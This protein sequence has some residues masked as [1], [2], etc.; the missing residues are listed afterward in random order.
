MPY[1]P[2]SYWESLHRRGDL[3]AVG[4]SGLPATLN[5]WLYRIHQRNL[6]ALIDA[7][8]VRPRTVFEIGAGTGVFVQ[9]WR[10]RGA[11]R[12]DGC[13]L[14]P[15]V[16][17]RLNVDHGDTGRFIQADVAEPIPAPLSDGYDVVSCMNVL[18]HI[19]DDALFERA[20]ANISRLVASGGWL[21]LTEPVLYN[22]EFEVPP[23]PDLSSRARPLALYR[24]PAEASGLQLVEVRASTALGN[25]PI[26]ARNRLRYWG[27]RALWAAVGAPCR[28]VPAAARL[29]GPLLWM[30]DPWALRLGAAPSG[31]LVLFR[32]PSS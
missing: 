2:T 10:G 11:E 15:S 3:S 23:R 25:N 16:V 29:V 1:V 27:W 17:D 20:V 24:G 12:I 18:L 28:L 32:R 4:Q 6:N 8:R 19:T 21:V 31:K 26:E 7:F 9:Y 14:V 22:A 5:Q 13:D 30:F